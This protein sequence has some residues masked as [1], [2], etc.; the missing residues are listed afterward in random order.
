MKESEKQLV[1]DEGFELVFV[2][3]WNIQRPKEEFGIIK[4]EET[5]DV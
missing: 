2:G 1:D 5:K 3:W 4:L